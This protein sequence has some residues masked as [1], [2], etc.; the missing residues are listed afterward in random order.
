MSPLRI[1][2]IS[3]LAVGGVAAAHIEPSGDEP[4]IHV[5]II[6]GASSRPGAWVSGP[7]ASSVWVAKDVRLAMDTEE[8]AG[9]IHFEPGVAPSVKVAKAPT[10]TTTE[11]DTI[12]Q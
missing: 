8:T 5:T 12:S 11:P 9:A 6:P 2:L 3:L 4:L 7:L 1:G 10:A